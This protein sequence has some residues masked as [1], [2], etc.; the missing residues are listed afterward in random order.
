MWATE[1]LPPR[2]FQGISSM[3]SQ[4]FWREHG[5]DTT[6]HDLTHLGGVRRTRHLY[7]RQTQ[8]GEIAFGGGQASSRATTPRPTRRALK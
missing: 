8:S 4:H 7:G 5:E 3:E 6:P 2:V 1:P